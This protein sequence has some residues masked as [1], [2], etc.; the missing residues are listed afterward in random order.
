LA[1]L[2]TITDVTQPLDTS[3][4]IAKPSDSMDNGWQKVQSQKSSLNSISKE[5]LETMRAAMKQTKI[6]VVLRVPQDTEENYSAAETHLNTIC[7]LAKQDS[8]MVILDA[9]G[10][11][12]INIHKTFSAEKYKEFFNPREKKLPNGMLQVSVAHHIL[13]ETENFNKTLLI[14]FL[15]KHK[16]YVH[17]NQKDGLEHFTEHFTAIG[18]LFGPHPELSWCDN[19]R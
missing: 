13:S 7:K 2:V 11:N 18:I 17:F 16:A 9:K 12:H 14:P 10:V 1:S 6:T 8:N 5:R 4:W 19:K 3:N 15:T